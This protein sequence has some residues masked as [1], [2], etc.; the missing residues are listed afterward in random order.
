MSPIIS[1]ANFPVFKLLDVTP[2]VSFTIQQRGTTCAS[3]ST[4]QVTAVS[5]SSTSSS[6]NDGAYLNS[7]VSMFGEYRKVTFVAA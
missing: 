3:S 5:Q 6:S 4:Q 1:P 2:G 7:W